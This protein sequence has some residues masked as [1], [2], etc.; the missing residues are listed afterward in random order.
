MPP[1]AKPIGTK[2]AFRHKWADRGYTLHKTRLV[3][4]GFVQKEGVD[5]GDTYAPVSSVIFSSLNEQFHMMRIEP[6]CSYLSVELPLTPAPDPPTQAPPG[7]YR[8]A[9]PQ[10]HVHS[11]LFPRLQEQAADDDEACPW[12]EHHH[13]GFHT[14]PGRICWSSTLVP[15]VA[16][17]HYFF[18][19]ALAY[20]CG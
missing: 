6:V 10:G 19:W 16:P 12:N 18:R 17:L 1:G 15:P 5:Y 14:S 2:W 3:A 8:L 4:K 13:N 11:S 20:A 9:T 7:S